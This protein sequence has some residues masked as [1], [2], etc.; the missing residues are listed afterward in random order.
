M[1]E[2][3]HVCNGIRHHGQPQAKPMLTRKVELVPVGDYE[4]EFRCL[5]LMAD[6]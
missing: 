1:Y 4:A 6:G 5:L 3:M 2:C